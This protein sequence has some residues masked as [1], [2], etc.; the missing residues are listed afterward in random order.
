MS[1]V[2]FIVLRDDSHKPFV[3]QLSE[4]GRSRLAAG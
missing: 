1:P 4:A 2:H 3:C